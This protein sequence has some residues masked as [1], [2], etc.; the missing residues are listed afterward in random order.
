MQSCRKPLP[1]ALLLSALAPLPSHAA[2]AC[3]GG[4]TSGTITITEKKLEP[5][6]ATDLKELK[7]SQRCELAKDQG[8][9][10]WTLYLVAYLS[11][12]PGAGEVNLLFYEQ[13]SGKPDRPGNEVNSFPLKT[14]K[15][16]KIMMAE[17]EIKPEEGFKAGGRYNVLITRL[18]GGRE[19]V[20][21]RTTLELK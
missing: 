10:G 9:G 20:F 1:V 5:A 18:V 14:K 11:R 12:M 15:D 3:P 17:V 4:G 13:G 7:A 6:Q 8:S 19:E 2:P 16:A 21:A